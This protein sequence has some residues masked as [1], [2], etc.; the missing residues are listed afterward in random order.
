MSQ[1]TALIVYNGNTVGD[2][3]VKGYKFK[4]S[5]P[6]QVEGVENIKYIRNQGGFSVISESGEEPTPVQPVTPRRRRRVAQESLAQSDVVD[7]E[8]YW[9]PEEGEA[10][11]EEDEI[12]VV[13][14]EPQNNGE[15]TASAGKL[16]QEHQLTVAEVE[17]ITGTGTEGRVVKGDVQRYMNSL[18]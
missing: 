18:S 12:E 4:P 14:S 16:I 13:P 11:E 2:Y 8:K 1:A 9:S 7:S 6:Q 3:Y 10:F 17:A 15:V 5:V